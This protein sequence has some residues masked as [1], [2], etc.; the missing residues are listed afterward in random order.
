M[1]RH[2]IQRIAPVLFVLVSLSP[3]GTAA[4]PFA[5]PANAF[6]QRVAEPNPLSPLPSSLSPE[7]LNLLQFLA[8][9]FSEQTHRRLPPMFFRTLY[10]HPLAARQAAIRDSVSTWPIA[11][12]NMFAYALRTASFSPEP[13]T[14]PT[15]RASC[16]KPTSLTV[17]VLPIR[18]SPNPFGPCLAWARG[19]SAAWKLRPWSPFWSF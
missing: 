10:E 4:R 7:Q 13:F 17:T 11:A 16:F 8:P 3:I 6:P 5:N 14:A 15:A 2:L 9:S 1:A 18:N 19:R 12:S